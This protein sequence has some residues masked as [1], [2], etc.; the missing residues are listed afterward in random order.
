MLS[1]ELREDAADPPNNGVVV[2]NAACGEAP[3]G[4]RQLYYVFYRDSVEMRIGEG[5]HTKIARAASNPRYT[6][7]VWRRMIG[8]IDQLEVPLTTGS[9][10]ELEN[11]TDS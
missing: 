8:P 6:L 9:P 1:R 11:A 7:L 10:V 4:H 5:I 3:R 2:S